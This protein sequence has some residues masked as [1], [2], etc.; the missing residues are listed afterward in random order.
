[1]QKISVDNNA[2]VVFRTH[3]AGEQLNLIRI[4]RSKLE[5]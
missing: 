4:R 5:L 3:L 2:A 1:M